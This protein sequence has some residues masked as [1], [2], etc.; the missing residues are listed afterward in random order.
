MMSQNLEI[1]H[2]DALTEGRFAGFKEHRLVTGRKLW[3]ERAN[4]DAWDGIGDFVYL[5]V[6]QFN[7]KGETTMHPKKRST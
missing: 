2:R 1:L 4:P 3:G 6:A 7:P 5:A